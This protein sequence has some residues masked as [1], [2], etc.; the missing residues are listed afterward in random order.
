MV[1]CCFKRDNI[2]VGLN[3]KEC[4]A[5]CA[6]YKTAAEQ[7]ESVKKANKRLARLP[8]SE[9]KTIA[10]YYYRNKKVWL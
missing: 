6:F 3:I 8:M 1:D 7:E 4:P 9:Q 5:N 2:C 10:E